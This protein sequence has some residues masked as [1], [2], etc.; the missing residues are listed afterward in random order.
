VCQALVG[1]ARKIVGGG[2]GTVAGRPRHTCYL[3]RG[4]VSLSNAILR[5]AAGGGAEFSSVG[6]LGPC[7]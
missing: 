1:G 2:R 7:D 5:A 3:S 4:P 6:P